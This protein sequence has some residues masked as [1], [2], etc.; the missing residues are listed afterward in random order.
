MRN[1]ENRSLV[2]EDD[3]KGEIEPIV[4]RINHLEEQVSNL[5]TAY[6]GLRDLDVY[7][8]LIKE[9]VSLVLRL[10]KKRSYQHEEEMQKTAQKHAVE[11]L[12]YL[13]DI[14]AD[15]ISLDQKHIIDESEEL[16]EI[17][18]L[19][20]EIILFGG[21][22]LFSAPESIG[23][24]SRRMLKIIERT[25]MKYTRQ[26]EDPDRQDL[27]I[28]EG[29]EDILLS[30]YITIPLSQAV[31]LIEEELIPQCEGELKEKP[32]DPEL[33]ERIS[34]LKTQAE[35]FRAAKF[36]PRARPIFPQF[37]ESGI[38]TDAIVQYTPEGEMV[39]K[40]KLPAILSTGNRYDL[41]LESMKIQIVR[42]AVGKGLDENI[43]EAEKDVRA[44]GSSL[45]YLQTR[46]LFRELS[47]HFP[48]LRRL[49][50]R[51]EFKRLVSFAE[52]G[53]REGLHRALERMMIHDRNLLWTT[54][55]LQID[56]R[57]K[58][59]DEE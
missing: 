52:S 40:M 45:D 27:E 3:W 31:V 15:T 17:N 28:E 33:Q 55:P 48:F 43:D 11:A 2:P 58:E 16:K 35:A 47:Y 46:K 34:R 9:K 59:E 36:F 14:T 10:L 39:I 32:G 26:D 23:K 6:G 21:A 24:K 8:P 18:S 7:F 49:E 22:P 1:D 50:N 57:N 13:E 56:G 51:E 4:G 54:E 30:D 19:L 12:D 41:L 25:L 38:Y 42:D 5:R 44:L 29:D 37:E 53:D 20:Q